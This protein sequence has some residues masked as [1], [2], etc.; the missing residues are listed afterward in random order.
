MPIAVYSIAEFCHAHRVS[1]AFFYNLLKRGKG[2]TVMKVGTR[3]L[4]SDE[5]AKD[6]RQRM[7]SL[8]GGNPNQ[9]GPRQ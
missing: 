1:K 7:E 3:T 5:A 6:W 9:G 8:T 4:V 2:P